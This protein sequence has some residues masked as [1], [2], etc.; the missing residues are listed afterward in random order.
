MTV[1]HWRSWLFWASL[2]LGL[3]GCQ[4][5]TSQKGLPQDPIFVSRQPLKAK[6]EML[7]PL[8][9]AYSEPAIPV[10]LFHAKKG[11]ALAERQ[12]PR[13]DTRIAGTKDQPPTEPRQVPGLLTNRS[14][15]AQRD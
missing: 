15:E 11:P 13:N 5:L 3:V 9:L 10:D 1:S 12:E 2:A 4:S 6:A 8:A 14:S 7:P